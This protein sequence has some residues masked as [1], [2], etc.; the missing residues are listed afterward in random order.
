M[1]LAIEVHVNTHPERPE[2]RPD[3]LAEA[4]LRL[5]RRTG[6]RRALERLFTLNGGI[7]GSIAQRHS[8]ASGESYEDLLQVGYV[9]LM[10]AVRGFDELKG[11][12]FSTY[13]HAMIEGEI[14]HYLRDAA[15]LQPVRR[16]RWARS[17]YAKVARATAELMAELG[18]PP[19]TE[20]IARKV[21]VT[22]EGIEE[23]M[24]V[25]LD[26]SV[27]SLDATGPEKGAPP[28]DLSAIR[29]LH[30]E[31]FALPIEDRIWLEEAMET[32]S[33]LQRKVLHHL[34]YED[35]SQSET[36]ERLGLSQRK[37]SRIAAASI[38]LLAGRA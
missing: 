20:E 33:E 22:P 29:S 4:G 1:T 17:L 30:H 25:Y 5:Y 13:A 16:P 36:G 6:D 18:R 35:L 14:R 9:G 19:L 12:R 7:L 26:T 24:K 11:T 15:L 32:L 8:R 28:P 37:V 10:K 31:T 27:R 23:L 3:R 34:Y 21:N 2:G 38:K